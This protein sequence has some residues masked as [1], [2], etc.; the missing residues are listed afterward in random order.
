MNLENNNKTKKLRV[1]ILESLPYSTCK[2][3]YQ[4]IVVDIWKETAQKNKLD[5][6]ITC[7]TISYDDAIKKL[8]D[9]EIDILL[10]EISVVERRFDWAL[11]SRPFFVSEL[12][13]YRKEERNFLSFLFD[14]QIKYIFSTVL[15]FILVY[16]FI[17][18]YIFKFSVID[19][20]YKTLLSFLSIAGEIISQKTRYLKKIYIKI[21]NTIW[22][23]FVFFFRSFILSRIIASVVINNNIIDDNE[24]QQINKVNV[25]KGSAYVDMVKFLGKTPVEIATSPEIAKKVYD[26]NEKEYWFEDANTLDAHLKQANIVMKLTKTERPVI[27]DEFTIAVNKKLPHILDIINKSLV[28]MQGN[29]IILK[30]CRGYIDNY[31]RCLL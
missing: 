11:Y 25:L 16:S 27:N 15:F 18:V 19:A 26:S 6:E 4:G 9:D 8:N 13:I 28:E 7:L 24:L 29:G 5:Y 1:G 14:V 12:Y 23:T 2:P 22:S 21:L 3:T 20:V 31:D 10:A 30:I 17:F